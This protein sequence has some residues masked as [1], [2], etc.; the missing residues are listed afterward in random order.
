M[1]STVIRETELNNLAKT[2]QILDGHWCSGDLLQGNQVDTENAPEDPLDRGDKFC[3]VGALAWIIEPEVMHRFSE[4][5]Y[6]DDGEVEWFYMNGDAY[7]VVAN[8]EE[9]RV[10]A[11]VIAEHYLEKGDFIIDPHC[12][13]EDS[14]NYY[15]YLDVEAY[16]SIDQYVD[17]MG[18][19]E[20]IFNFNDNQKKQEPVLE[21]IRRAAER[22]DAQK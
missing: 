22:F 15:R 9:G 20:V 5:S 7:Q 11:T 13:E 3:A 17:N 12:E 4:P 6:N 8:S 19:D 21:M 16:T 18:V 2:A 1:T 10:L 14:E